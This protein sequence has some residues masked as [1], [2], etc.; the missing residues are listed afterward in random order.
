MKMDE[1]EHEVSASTGKFFQSVQPQRDLESNWAVDLA[2]NLELYLLKICSGEITG[3]DGP[4]PSINF[5]EAALLLQ[6]SIQ[7][8]SRKVEY[9]HSLVLHALEFLSQKS[10]QEQTSDPA[11]EQLEG[12]GLSTAVNE[13]NDTFWDLDD[14]PVDQKSLLDDIGRDTQHNFVRPPANLVVLEGDC[15]DTMG[16]SGELESYLLATNDLYRDFIILDSSDAVTVD[17]F[18][19]GDYKAANQKKAVGKG[20]S[21]TSKGR[22]SFQSP[23]G[24]SVGIGHKLPD[25]DDQNSSPHISPLVNDNDNNDFGPDVGYAD[26]DYSEDSDDDPW[27][28]LN[29]HEPGNLKIKPF[30]RLSTNRR[31]GLGPK[32][33][34]SIT[35]E[36]PLAPLC[37][38]ISSELTEIWET[39]IL[40]GKNDSICPPPYEKLRQSLLVQESTCHDDFRSPNV[41]NEDYDSGDENVGP[42]DFD[43]PYVD[44]ETPSYHDEDHGRNVHF[45][46]D[47]SDGDF[48]S[49]SNLEDLCRSHMDALLAKL[50]ESE[51]QTEMAARVSTWKQR[52][53][54]NLE[55]Q[56]SRAPFDIHEYGEIV[57]D[58]LSLEHCSPCA[59]SFTDIVRGQK[60]HDV[61]RTFS[62]LLQLVNNG[63][64]DLEK[65][66]SHPELVC[67]TAMNPFHVR[68]LKHDKKKVNVKPLFSK[69]RTITPPKKGHQRGV[70]HKSG[71]ENQPVNTP[72]SKSVSSCRF[73]V[74]VGKSGSTRCTPESKRRKMRIVEPVDIHLAQ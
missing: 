67:Y 45:D 15:L 31:H 62:A 23:I 4:P 32:R 13:D 36:F 52:I 44:E 26:S 40:K 66:S 73:S 50:T 34:I 69:K 57:L 56:D 64:V 1:A 55:E 2:K 7:V 60:K 29:P 19:N 6:G 65:G 49:Q 42:P 43:M 59:M 39:R 18:L 17:D 38:P 41:N 3:Q 11:S 61:A 21:L 63:D 5:A 8:Y 53:E 33:E 12:S 25:G 46:N 9:L 70:K 30:K 71:K 28:P 20:D 22:K 58:K 14:I 68:L 47:I 48:N 27:K 35:K 51:K 74:R 72:P 54:Q 16:D 10:S 24:H 37:G